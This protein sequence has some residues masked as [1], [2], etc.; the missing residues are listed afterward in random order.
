MLE[1]LV[2]IADALVAH[3]QALGARVAEEAERAQAKP[4]WSCLSGTICQ[5]G[6][7]GGGLMTDGC[8]GTHRR[9]ASRVTRCYMASTTSACM[10]PRSKSQ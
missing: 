1:R 2:D 4:G 8:A 7:G 3:V 9:S 5:P 6:G 10:T